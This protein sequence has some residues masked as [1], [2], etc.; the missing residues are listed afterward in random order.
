[1]T[2]VKSGLVD[3]VSQEHPGYVIVRVGQG[4]EVFLLSKRI[5]SW[6]ASWDEALALVS[7]NERPEP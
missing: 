7:L 2:W 3:W 1:M 6:V 5:G 4:F